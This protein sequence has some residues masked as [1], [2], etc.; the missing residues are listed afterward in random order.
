VS[1]VW[2]VGGRRGGRRVRN[3]WIGGWEANGAQLLR[4]APSGAHGFSAIALLLNLE[5]FLFR[6]NSSNLGLRV[7]P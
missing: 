7:V 1:E 2:V 3:R 5:S 4:S 6:T